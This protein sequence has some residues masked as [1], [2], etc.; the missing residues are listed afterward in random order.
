MFDFF[1]INLDPKRGCE[2]LFFDQLPLY[3]GGGIALGKNESLSFDSAMNSLYER[4]LL[5][6]LKDKPLSLRI[7]VS[8]PSL[9]TL[10][11]KTAKG[12]LTCY[13]RQHVHEP[14]YQASFPF[15]LHV[16]EQRAGRWFFTVDAFEDPIIVEAASWCA[17][18]RPEKIRVALI[19][20]TFRRE[21]QVA[22]NI[23]RLID[24]LNPEEVGDVQIIVIDNAG[25]FSPDADIAEHIRLIHQPNLGGAGG[26]GRGIHEVLHNGTYTHILLMDD[27]AELD[28][29]SIR[30]A[31]NLFAIGTPDDVFIGGMQLDVYAPTRV[32]DAG[33]HWSPDV[34]EQPTGRL[35]VDDLGKSHLR[36]MLT[37]RFPVNFNGWWLFGGSRTAFEKYGRPLP[38]FVHLDDVEYGVRVSLRGGRILCVPGIFIWHEPYYSKLEGWFAYYNIRNELI[39]W[40]LQSRNLDLRRVGQR[41]R[42]RYERLVRT[43]Q[44]GSAALLVLAIEDFLKGPALIVDGN[45][46]AIHERVMNLFC[47]FNANYSSTRIANDVDNEVSL[48]RRNP[49]KTLLKRLTL[50]G[51]RFGWLYSK[52]RGCIV[53]DECKDIDWTRIS[54]RHAWGYIDPADRILH[55]FRRDPLAF[56]KIHTR[57]KKT[58][59][60][61][62]RG[63]A[64]IGEWKEKYELLASREFWEEYLARHSPAS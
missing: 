11:H 63:S 58:I 39:R 27:D 41:L 6:I 26:F 62:S 59:K 25:T 18:L 13:G 20:C 61:F 7:K 33:G 54:P 50:N 56:E 35:P 38:I 51:N 15:T 52:G 23:R 30:R 55:S 29:L 22:A 64:V 16:S 2:G 42:R 36:E 31:L 34:F 10:W 8:G 48:T 4:E 47:E 17:G 21:K 60:N 9:V 32:A 12:I 40:S 44:Y 14:P 37:R 19:I 1:P 3:L 5:P 49:I 53:F 24:G 46:I 28:L 45:T 57:F 43:Y